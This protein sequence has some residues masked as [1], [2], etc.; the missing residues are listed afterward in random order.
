MLQ[1]LIMMIMFAANLVQAAWKD[2]EETR[3]LSLDAEGVE[4]LQIEAGAGSLDVTGV[5]GGERIEV[6]A[7]IRVP[8]A[9]AEEAREL[10]GDSLILGLDRDGGRAELKG[11]FEDAG[12]FFGSS[13]TVNLEVRLPEGLSLGMQDS[14]GSIAVRNVKGDI[15]LDDGSGSIQ[16]TDVGGNLVVQ[17]GS[18]SIVI[19]GAGGEV[20]VVD[21]SGTVSVMRVDGSVTI[22][23]GSGSIDVS[24]VAGDLSIPDAGSGSVDYSSIGGRVQQA[25]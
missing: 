12:G 19:K 21:G 6:A 15:A 8:Q 23:D 22:D 10:I 20:S 16:L 18:G 13:P 14:S 7:L 4:A 2:Y 1:T 9:D 11:Y 5:A 3:D 17:D 25:D 24:E